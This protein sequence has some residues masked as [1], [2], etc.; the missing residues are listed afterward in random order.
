VSDV[1]RYRRVYTRLWTHPAFVALTHEERLT[2]LYLL[3]GPQ[4]N[5][6][7]FFRVSLAGAAEDLKLTPRRFERHLDRICR[8]FQWRYDANARVLH[9]P[10]WWKFNEPQNPKHLQGCLTDLVDVPPTR[11]LGD[12][13]RCVETL[14]QTIRGLF[15]QGMRQHLA[16]RMP[17]GIG[18]G[19]RND[20]GNGMRY[21]E[22]EQEQEQEQDQRQEQEGEQEQEQEGTTPAA[23]ERAPTAQQ[24]LSP[25]TEPADDGNYAVIVK[26]AHT[27]MDATKLGDPTNGDLVEALKQACAQHHI[28]YSEPRVI[29]KALEAAAIQRTLIPVSGKRTSGSVA[30]MAANLR[31]ARTPAEMGERLRAL[32][33]KEPRS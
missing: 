7:G 6:L 17:K 24:N 13:A 10:S 28:D 27:V 29:A 18:E 32:A 30:S 8:A 4:S 3:T 22:Q 9:I 5:R 2:V 25:S 21:Q 1:G 11:L 15:E 14:P 12:F 23:P 16:D 33:N 26:L 31:A 20:I 19:I